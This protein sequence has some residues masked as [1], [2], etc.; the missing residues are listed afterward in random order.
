MSGIKL[1]DGGLAMKSRKVNKIISALSL[2]KAGWIFVV[3]N[4]IYLVLCDHF[5]VLLYCSIIAVITV[6][7]FIV[8]FAV[9]LNIEAKAEIQQRADFDKLKLED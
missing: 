3:L 2:T 5:G 1:G 8:V 6:T 9:R 7:I 4:T